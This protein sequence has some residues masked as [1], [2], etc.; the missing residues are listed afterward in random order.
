MCRA[1]SIPVACHPAMHH[2][3]TR[4]RGHR[5]QGTP[6]NPPEGVMGT[7]PMPE[8]GDNS[9][10]HGQRQHA[11][12]TVPV[13]PWAG[14]PAGPSALSCS[15]QH[16]T[17]P[18]CDLQHP[19]RSSI[20]LRAPASCTIQH[21]HGSSGTILRAPA[22]SCELQH[23]LECSSTT[24]QALEPSWELQHNAKSSS[25]FLQTTAPSRMLQSCPA[26]SRTSLHAPAL[27]CMLQHHP[28]CS[29]I[30]LHTQKPPCELWPAAAVQSILWALAM[31][32][33][34]PVTSGTSRTPPSAQ[35]APAGSPG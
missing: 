6:A 17:A 11:P 33:H 1:G 7:F 28:T 27:S 29:S 12:R 30:I 14:D 25:T 19:A 3:R 35:R 15:P 13:S 10:L 4:H 31:L 26:S 32:W 2:P 18:P 34:H 8:G 23:L 20:A 16:L 22:P 5:G 24:L 21:H 9:H